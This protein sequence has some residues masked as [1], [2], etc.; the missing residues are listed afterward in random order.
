MKQVVLSLQ[1]PRKSS[2][3]VVTFLEE[4]LKQNN[5]QLLQYH[6]N[7]RLFNIDLKKENSIA[8][9][10][11]EEF[12]DTFNLTNLVKSEKCLINNHKLTIDLILTNKPQS[13]QK[14]NVTET[15][16]SDCHKLI[17]AFMKY[18]ISRLKPK[19]AQYHSYKNF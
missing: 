16:V 5:K 3:N 7:G 8:Y 19:N 17:T 11:L 6:I 2:N 13:F 10:K 15:G 14:K 9:G 4:L 12:C 18:Y 1:S